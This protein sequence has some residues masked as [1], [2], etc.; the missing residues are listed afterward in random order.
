M[1][2]FAVVKLRTIRSLSVPGPGPQRLPPTKAT[3]IGSGSSFEIERRARVGCPFT[4]L[5]PKISESGKEVETLTAR[6][7]D[8]EGTSTS[9]SV[10]VC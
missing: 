4:S 5:T 8:L 2:Y 6:L 3:L 7:G 10:V 1:L 9:S